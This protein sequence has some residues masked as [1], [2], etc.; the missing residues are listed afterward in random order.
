MQAREKRA[1][2]GF[3]PEAAASVLASS[4]RDQGNAARRGAPRASQG[5]GGPADCE[6]PG[7][8]GESSA[9]APGRTP[10]RESSAG[11]RRAAADSEPRGGGAS[12]RGAPRRLSGGRDA[13]R[14]GGGHGGALP[15]RIVLRRDRCRGPKRRPPANR[16]S[17]APPARRLQF[18]PQHR[19]AADCGSAL[20]RHDC[21]PLRGLRAR[22][23]IRV[24]DYGLDYL[25]ESGTTG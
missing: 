13:A 24:W 9:G 3:L 17:A 1:L 16:A 18:G 12:A 23:S 25:S 21:P 15:V 20:L 5:P 22:L 7:E 11:A 6:P 14:S 10:Q 8:P 4:P 19:P 2:P